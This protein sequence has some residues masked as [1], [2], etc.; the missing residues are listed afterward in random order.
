MN[1]Q[2]YISLAVVIAYIPLAFILI[3]NRPWN[4]QQKLFAMMLVPTFLWGLSNVIF[5]SSFFVQEKLLVLRFV[6]CFFVWTAVQ[7]HYFLTSFYQPRG[8]RPLFAYALL[9]LVTTITFLG[10]FAKGVSFINGIPI[11]NYDIA[12]IPVAI[13]L[14]ILFALDFYFLYRKFQNLADPIK[15]NQIL[16]LLASIIL[17]TFFSAISATTTGKIYPLAHLGAVVNAGILTY[18]VLRHR[19]LDMQ[20]VFR[21][22][23]V[24]I[25]L[26]ATGISIYALLFLLI[27]RLIDTEPDLRVLVLTALAGTTVAI[28]IYLLQGSFLK[29]A[30][31]FF[32]KERYEYHQKLHTFLKNRLSSIFSLTELGEELL[33]LLAGVLNCKHAYLLLPRP[34]NGDF[35]VEI[36]TSQ[37]GSS[38]LLLTIR[39]ES[40]ILQWLKRENCYLSKE[41]L[42]IYAEFRGLWDEERKALEAL[43]IQLLFPVMSRGNLVAILAMDRKQ[44][45]KYSVEDIN[46]AESIASQVATS[47]EKEYLQEQ[48]RRREQELSLIN[49]L[50]SVITSSLNIREVYDAFINELNQV[51]DVDWAGIGLIEGD[52]LCFEAL[53]TKVGSAWQPGQRIPLAGT[54]VQW[55]ASHKR[56]CVEPDL[57][58]N[59]RFWTGEHHL[60]QGIH[61][62]IYLPLVTKNEAIG[63]LIIGSQ[64]P[65][66]Y[67]P[68][69]VRLLERLASQIAVPIEN[70]R[71]YAKAEQ[72]ARVDELT[73]LFNRRHFDE[74]L[75]QE[76][77]RHSRYSGMLSLILLDLD[78]FK[79]YND[80]HGHMNGDKVLARIGQTISKSIRSTDLAFRYG[81]DEFA[82]LLPQ[83]PSNDAFIVAERIRARIA[84]EMQTEQPKI[85]ASLGLAS[86]PSDGIT[87]DE[88]LTAADR[89]LYYAKQT[90]GNRTC[91]ASRILPSL[92][93]ATATGAVSEKEALSIIYALAAAIEAKDQYTYGHSKK[94]CSYAVALAEALG[95]PPERVAIISTAALLHDIGKIGIPDE[96]LNKVDKLDA[97]SWE[98]IQSHPKLSATIVGHVLSLVS[99]LP[100][101]LHHHERW[102]GTGY[103]S[104]LK[105]E[106]IPIEARIL[107]I[108]DA[109][110]A[111]SS[112]RPYRG[113]L[114]YKKVL[115][116]LKRCAGTQFDPKLVEAFLPI[117]LATTPAELIIGE[118][119]G[120]PEGG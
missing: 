75:K 92:T 112:A 85:T 84:H 108:A 69:Q 111:M 61:S 90:G 4:R 35:A 71:L 20:I 23:L 79:A 94:V 15:R 62:I 39:K 44:T 59:R 38:Q 91:M 40:P 8:S 60:K 32:R 29:G 65:N 28:G 25:G 3:S 42:D 57:S 86:W 52:E 70:S 100:A 116:E 80:K 26:I 104:G 24:W 81:G 115:A 56:A 46:L 114:C 89:A 51:V 30:E 19:L 119:T 101:I 113:A 117:A 9:A 5:R 66:A 6:L 97:E 82:I 109:F 102:D 55:V 67:N 76:I 95:L 1:T 13:A 48:L 106:A 68:E 10:Y 74:H 93:E 118:D 37:Q 64:R 11:P 96:V 43:D 87:P 49:R 21:R 31:R 120:N 36:G 58:K 77:E 78:F 72:R 54:G 34:G 99:C 88:I 17:M 50:T 22:G 16:Y 53:S 63:G 14:C 12:L 45:G 107:A 47:L 7:F 41:N 18:A 103:P 27:H 33:P 2:A 73:N 110:D 98:L 105:G 83:S